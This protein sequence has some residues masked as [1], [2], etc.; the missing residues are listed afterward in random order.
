M[1]TLVNSLTRTALEVVCRIDDSELAKIPATGP[2]ILYCNHTGQVEVPLLYTELQPRRI[3][4]M[5]KS[6][7][8]D[9]WFLR[10][11]LDL[12]GAIPIHRGEADM[13]AM[14]AALKALE[15][16]Q[17]L[18]I[19]PEGTLNKT[20]VLR[21][22]HSGIVALAIRSGAPLIPLAHWGSERL[23]PNLKRVRRTDFHIR[24][25]K[26]FKLDLGR[27]RATRVV[28]RQLLD[29]MMFRLSALLPRDYRG[30]YSGLDQATNEH[31]QRVDL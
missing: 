7:L 16:G 26:P 19:A 17:I 9:N 25:G 4:G 5:A 15:Q 2:L 6:E 22:A 20:G 3:T 21:R 29:Q 27:Q 18:A 23:I 12:W 28:R 14:R 24:V 13:P 8:W 1:K 31:L 10:K 30:A 11:L